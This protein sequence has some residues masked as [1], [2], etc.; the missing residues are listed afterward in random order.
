MEAFGHIK[1]QMD[2][3]TEDLITLTEVLAPP[4]MEDERGKVFAKMLEEAGVDSIWTD[5]VGNVIGLR[6]GTSGESGYV[7]VDAHLD[8]VFPKEQMLRLKSRRYLKSTRYW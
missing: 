4:F 1:A 5:K 2:Q 3:T 6:K 8:V 7:G